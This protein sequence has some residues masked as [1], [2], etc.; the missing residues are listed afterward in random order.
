[1]T[2]P[3]AKEIADRLVAGLDPIDRS[4][5]PAPEFAGV[6]LTR[7]DLEALTA[8]A[9]Q[10]VGALDAWFVAVE[11]GLAIKEAEARRLVSQMAGLDREKQAEQIELQMS[12][13]RAEVKRN[14]DGPDAPRAAHQ[15]ALEKAAALADKFLTIYPDPMAMLRAEGWRNAEAVGR[16]VAL[17]AK[18]PPYA[19]ETAKAHAIA[20][21]DRNF[22][23][24]L[25]QIVDGISDIS[26]RPFN[27]AEFARQIVGAE[28]DS[29]KLG[30]DA[31]K[32]RAEASSIRYRQFSGGKTATDKIALG[33]AL[34]KAG[35][36]G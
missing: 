12:V 30:I 15:A 13:A 26:K 1:M 5:D 29:I 10:S 14:S 19:F 27:A 21:G 16:Y 31:L 2:T 32:A 35:L 4:S 23:A 3:T 11:K 25:F 36:R 33:L 34:R 9:S 22:A 20:S 6:P 24:A 17:L 7:K 28:H 8:K 18:L